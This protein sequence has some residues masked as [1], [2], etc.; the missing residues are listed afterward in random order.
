[1]TQMMTSIL[2]LACNMQTLRVVNKSEKVKLS[3]KLNLKCRRPSQVHLQSDQKLPDNKPVGL[4]QGQC[5][6]ANHGSHKCLSQSSQ[7]LHHLPGKAL[8]VAKQARAKIAL[9]A[10][11]QEE[12]QIHPKSNPSMGNQ[13]NVCMVRALQVGKLDIGYSSNLRRV[14]CQR[15]K[16]RICSRWMYCGLSISNTRERCHPGN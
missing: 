9:I 16:E 10:Q 6:N 3:R 14:R 1:M 12:E 2:A 15:D 5:K 4:Y 13:V 11:R 7:Q 8:I